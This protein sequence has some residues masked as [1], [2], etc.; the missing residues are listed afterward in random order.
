MKVG[1]PRRRFL[2]TGLLYLPAALMAPRLGAQIMLPHRRAAAVNPSQA[3]VLSNLLAY[4]KLEEA[5][6]TRADASGNGNSLTPSSP[7]G[8]NAVGIIGNAANLNRGSFEYLSAS[9]A[10]IVNGTKGTVNMTW[11]AWVKPVNESHSPGPAIVGWWQSGG[12]HH[13]LLN[14]NDSGFFW[15]IGVY[16]G[17]STS[18]VQATNYGAPTS[19]WQMVAVW[20]DATNSKMGISVNAG[21]A[22]S[23]NYSGGMTSNTSN[24]PYLGRN[25]DSSLTYFNGLIDET[26]VWTKVLTAADLTYLYNS[27]LARTYPF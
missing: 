10:G 26:G 13:Y 3:S 20:H 23:I 9:T 22:N 27:G 24:N 8:G 2:K 7:D 25:Q 5:S 17:E 4:W 15:N 21:T 1:L 6:G 16:P 12:S 18:T 14:F 11:V 19:N